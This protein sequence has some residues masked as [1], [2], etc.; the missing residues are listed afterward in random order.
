M[1]YGIAKIC[2]FQITLQKEK[3]SDVTFNQEWD[4]LG[5]AKEGRRAERAEGARLKERWYKTG[6]STF[7]HST[8]IVLPMVPFLL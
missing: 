1:V 4:A 2:V 6:L 8:E 3:D 7:V 5:G